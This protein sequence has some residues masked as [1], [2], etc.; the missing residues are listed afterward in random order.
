MSTQLNKFSVVV[1]FAA[2]AVVF[3]RQKICS[4]FS[5]II[6]EKG[7]T[8]WNEER[9]REREAKTPGDMGRVSGVHLKMYKFRIE[10]KERQECIRCHTTS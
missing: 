2:V 9:A 5:I 3:Y 6:E 4:G 1:Y 8:E 7:R 10:W